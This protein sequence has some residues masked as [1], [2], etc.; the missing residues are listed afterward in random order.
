MTERRRNLSVMAI[1]DKTRKILVKVADTIRYP[2]NVER[3]FC[4]ALD[5]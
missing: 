5:V 3:A 2:A 4:A 1:T